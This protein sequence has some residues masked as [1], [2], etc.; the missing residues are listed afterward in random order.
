MLLNVVLLA[1]V[2]PCSLLLAF[3]ATK[4]GTVKIVDAERRLMANAMLDPRNTHFILV[5]E[6]TVSLF[7]FPFVYEYFTTE[8]R[9]FLMS[10][11]NTGWH[12]KRQ[13]EPFIPKADWAKGDAWFAL[14]R[15]HVKLV[16]ADTEYYRFFKSVKL[17]NGY[18]EHYS[19][20]ILRKLDPDGLI[21]HTP[22][23]SRWCHGPRFSIPGAHPL[24]YEY[25]QITPGFISS[26]AGPYC[27]HG[28]PKRWRCSLFARKFRPSTLD[29]LMKVLPFSDALSPGDVDQMVQRLWVS[30]SSSSTMAELPQGGVP[31]AGRAPGSYL[32]AWRGQMEKGKVG[33]RAEGGTKEGGG[34]AGAEAEG[35]GTGGSVVVGEP[36]PVLSPEEEELFH[37]AL[38]VNPGGAPRVAFLFLVREEFQ[39]AHLWDKFFASHDKERYSVYVYADQGDGDVPTGHRGHTLG[40]LPGFRDATTIYWKVRKQ[41]MPG[42]FGS[43]SKG[44]IT[45]EGIISSQGNSNS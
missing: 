29:P 20:T 24:S 32:E 12:W 39:L 11:S 5:C 17:T 34:V 44:T 6:S 7:A 41:F 27:A 37:R 1:P 14:Q 33:A 15:R 16:L 30:S 21:S 28:D 18:D 10:P 45:S 8:S 25:W 42:A 35:N 19:Q 38:G 2:F 36:S 22:M 9:S 40:S 3:Q 43:R 23:K 31:G 26:L 13:F 4:W